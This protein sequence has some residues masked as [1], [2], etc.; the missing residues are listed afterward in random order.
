[1]SFFYSRDNVGLPGTA[2]YFKVTPFAT[3][4]QLLTYI[5]PELSLHVTHTLLL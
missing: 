5:T 3:A 4:S 1:M 2:V